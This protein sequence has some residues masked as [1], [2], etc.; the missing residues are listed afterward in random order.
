MT[1]DRYP[2]L[3]LNL[4]IGLIG[5]YGLLYGID[6]HD[7]LTILAGAS[8]IVAVI[9]TLVLQSRRNRRGND[10]APSS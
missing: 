7:W 2:N 4:L 5:L 9:A 1:R 10:S 8:V 3:A 6:S